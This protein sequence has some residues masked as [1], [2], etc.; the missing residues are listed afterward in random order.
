MDKSCLHVGSPPSRGGQDFCQP[1]HGRICD[2]PSP[3]DLEKLAQWNGKMPEQI[4]QCVHKLIQKHCQA[5][6][7]AP[8][9]SAW[10]GDFTY[11]ELDKLSNALASRL[12][13][14]GVGPEVFVP[15]CFEKSRWTPMA[16]VGVMK[17]G[18]AF[19]LLDPLH[20]EARLQSICSTVSAD[21]ILA[22]VQHQALAARLAKRMLV[23]GP[24]WSMCCK[25]DSRPNATSAVVTPSNAIYA[26]FTSGSTGT[27]KGVVITH[28]A[29]SSGV[30][31]YN[32]AL[33]LRNQARILQFASHAFDA[34]I[35]D[36]FT[37]FLSGSCVCIPSERARNNNLAAFITQYNVTWA[38]F[39][40]S[41]LAIIE[42]ERVP[43]LKTVVVAGEGISP[44]TVSRWSS[45]VRLV[46]GYGPSECAGLGAIQD[47]I[48][49]GS[50]VRN[51]GR[52]IA[53]VRWIVDPDDY[54][55]LLPIGAVGELLIEGPNVGREYINNPVKSAA[56]FIDPPAW[57][58]QF[59]GHPNSSRKMYRTGDLAKYTADGSLHFIGRKDSQVKLRGQR[60]EL[61]EVEHHIRLCFPGV[62]DVVAELVT[63]VEAGRATFLVAFIWATWTTQAACLET[64]NHSPVAD[65][66]E[67]FLAA[68][69]GQF[70]DAILEAESRLHKAVPAYMVPAVFLPVVAMPLAKSGKTDRRRLR[71]H[72]AVLSWSAM[73]VY[74]STGGRKREPATAAEVTL[75]Q[76]WA[77]VLK[78]STEN[79]AADDNFFRLG[80]DSISAMQMVAAA[81]ADGLSLT[82]ADIFHYPQL[83]R[84]SCVLQKTSTSDPQSIAPP[85]SLLGHEYAVDSARRVAME[86]CQIRQ[87]QIVDMYP[88]TALQEGLMAL[89]A[90]S[91][92]AYT[93]HLSYRIPLYSDVDLDRFHSAWSAVARANPILSTRIVQSDRG[94]LQVVVADDIRWVVYENEEAYTT[95]GPTACFGLGKPLVEMAIVKPAGEASSGRFILSMHHSVYDAWSL[96]LLLEQAET[97]FQG[98]MLLPRPFSPFIAYLSETN[99]AATAFWETEFSGLST[100]SFPLLP[101]PTY[102]ASPTKTLTHV[103][104]LLH[105]NN[106]GQFTLSTR[107]RLAW[108][109]TLSYIS[110][111]SDIVFGLTVTGRSAPVTDIQQI[112]G[113]TIAT[114]PLRI[115]LNWEATVAQAL[116]GIQEHSAQL[117]PYE[118][119]GLQNIQRLS[120]DAAAACQFQNL[121][122]VQPSQEDTG[123]GGLFIEGDRDVLSDEGAFNT[124]PLTL[125]CGLSSG[126]IEVQAIYDEQVLEETTVDRMLHQ[127]GHVLGQIDQH[128]DAMMGTVSGLSPMDQQQ[129]QNWNRE[130]PP[131]NRCV[132]EL[133]Q[134]RCWA[135]PAAPAVCAWDGN[136]SYGELD[137]LSSELAAHLASR[138]VG[139]EAFVPL[140]FEK[141]RWTP[142]AMVGVMKAGGAFVLLDPS[143]PQARL[144][145]ICRQVSAKVIVTSAANAAMVADILAPELATHVVTVG[146]DAVPWREY[147]S[148]LWKASSVVP[149][150]AVYAVFTSGSTG[151]P[152]GTVIE[153]SS[154]CTG[155]LAHAPALGL[156][157]S[158]RVFQFASYAFDNSIAN[159]LTTLLVGGCVCIPSEEARRS[160]LPQAIQ[161]LRANFCPLTPTVARI[162]EPASLP[163]LQTVVLLGEA[164]RRS[165]IEKWIDHVQLLN[166]YGP[167]ECSVIATARRIDRMKHDL[168]PR[169][170]GLATGC[171]CWIVDALDHR[172]LLPIGAVGELVIEGPIVGRGYLNDPE[173]TAA[174]FIEPPPWLH[175]F[176]GQSPGRRLYKTGDLVQYAVDGSLRFVGRK[177][178]QVK[179]R[180]QRIE[181][182]E[183]E[184]HLRQCWPGAQDVVAEVAALA[185]RPPILIAFIWGQHPDGVNDN[186]H[187]QE[188][189]ILAVP[190]DSFRAA[191][192]MAEAH[193][194]RSLPAYMVPALFLPVAAI[195]TTTT[196]KT[197]RRQLRERVA[198]L[199]QAEMEACT[200]PQVQKQMPTTESETKLQRLWA[201]V[202]H[203]PPETIGLDD[204]FFRLGGD[205]IVAMKLAGAAGEHGLG[206]TVSEV[207]HHPR[208]SELSTRLQSKPSTAA[209]ETATPFALLEQD[210]I[211]DVLGL[212]MKQCRVQR[213]QISNIYPCT[214]LQE[215]LM[216]LTAKAPGTY[217]ARVSYRLPVDINL[218]D[219]RAVW[220]RVANANPILN[221]RIIQS[222]ALGCFQ[223]VVSG[224]V[225]WAVHEHEDAHDADASGASFGIGEPLFCA[226]VI[227]SRSLSKPHRFILSM[228]HAVYDAWSLPLLLEQAEA[229]LQGKPLV[230]RP[231]SAFISY[232]SE[233]KA[234]AASFWQ[235]EFTELNTVSFPSLP[236]P[237]YIPSP[238]EALRH[239]IPLPPPNETAS[240]FTMSTKLRL[241]WALTLS[242]Y[243]NTS[244]IVF[245]LTVTGRGVPVAGIDQMTGPTIATIPLRIRF[246]W[247]RDDTVVQALQVVQDHSTEIIPYE[248]SGLQNIRRLSANA[249]AACQFQNLLAIQPRQKDYERGLF[250]E[251]DVKADQGP[252]ISYA[253]T[254]QCDLYT[255]SI[256]VE[257]NY[258]QQIIGKPKV[259]QL[260]YQLAHVIE[261]I[262][263]QPNATVKSI[264]RLL[265]P[266]DH[267]QLQQWNENEPEQVHQCVHGLVHE[268]CL[269]Q[270]DAPAICAWD[271]DF[272]YRQLDDLSGI[273]GAHL[274]S[275]GVGPEVFVPLCFEKSRWTPVAMVGVMK[276]GGAFVLLDPSHPQVRLQS[277]CQQVS[278]KL[279]VASAQNAAIAKELGVQVVTIGDNQRAWHQHDCK[280][281]A[282]GANP[283]NAV[284]AVFTSGSTG[285]PKGPVMEHASFSTAALAQIKSKQ[286]TPDIRVFQ[287]SS[288]A[289]DTCILDM[290]TTLLA[291]GC[292]CIPSE[293]DRKE[294]MTK[295]IVQLQ[296]NYIDL[297]PSFA[298]T[299]TPHDIPGVRTLL[300]GGEA[301]LRSDIDQ[302]QPYVRLIN[303]YG[304]AECSA[305]STS[306]CEPLP[307]RDALNIGK[308][309]GCV[310]WVV[311]EMDHD[312]LVPIGAVGE[313]MIEG[314]IVGRGYL[315]D[316]EKTAAAFIKP[317]VWMHHFRSP[318]HVSSGTLKLYK[319]GDLVQYTADGSLRFIGRKDTQVKLRGQRVELGE[320]EHNTRQCF[321]G[322]RDVVAEVVKPVEEGRSPMLVAFVWCGHLAVTPPP[323][324]G[325]GDGGDRVNHIKHV[326]AAPTDDFHAAISVARSRLHEVVPAYMVPALFLPLVMVPL[327]S[328][329]KA[330]RRQ[331]REGAASLSRAEID[332]YSGP[333]TAQR[334]PATAA[335]QTLQ[336]LW[337]RVFNMPA[338]DI[339]ANDNFFHLGGDSITAM[340]LAGAARADGLGL[341]VADVFKYPVLCRQ[342]TVISQISADVPLPVEPAPFSM[343]DSVDPESFRLETVAPN[344]PF[345]DSQVLDAFPTTEFQEQ[346]ISPY[347][348][349]YL[350][351]TI[352]GSVDP[353]RLQAAC[354][355][356][357]QRYPI[358]RTTFV[359]SD[360]GF[361][362][363]TLRHLDATMDQMSTRGE[364][365]DSSSRSLCSQDSASPLPFGTAPFK[366]FLVSEGDQSHTLI[367][368]LSHAQYDGISLPVMYQDLAATYQGDML[369]PIP[370]FSLYMQYRLSRR[371]ADVYQFWHDFL[372]NSAMTKLNCQAI[373]GGGHDTATEVPVSVTKSMSLPSPPV[374]ITMAT[375]VKAAWSFVLMQLT[376]QTDL[377][378][379]QLVNGR[380]V[381]IPGSER[382]LGPCISVIPM[383]VILQPG[384]TVWDLLDHV[385]TQQA[386]VLP[387]ETSDLRDIVPNSTSWPR[388]TDYQI[389]VHHESIGAD[390][391]SF[392]LNGMEC[393]SEIVA[394]PSI[395]RGL[396]VH[397]EQMGDS[398]NVLISASS[399]VVNSAFA[400]NI[401]DRLCET[402]SFFASGPDQP[403]SFD[404]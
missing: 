218:D 345:D 299:L 110:N 295:A 280:R 95:R 278:A 266:G 327:T 49:P 143:H 52:A 397:S 88:C 226:S 129:L 303:A 244:D 183:V 162:L 43:C 94:S 163:T 213:S 214:A 332:V 320:V 334:M 90:K 255:D 8:A 28:S 12:S 242:A 261:Q 137:T 60:I 298:R 348:S 336:H 277:I 233:A 379:G 246:D 185:G 156:M 58:H 107:L 311:D 265:S 168:D 53:S 141:S 24:E 206:L 307:D 212:A 111:T 275:Q 142:V 293:T 59:R 395:P 71:D 390:D 221:T 382:I 50:D 166:E 9:V 191:I 229:A 325:D 240:D 344:L 188:D 159:T 251:E 339:G 383:R 358:L 273:L 47:R 169:N 200:G 48:G 13:D 177:D 378:Y 276:A 268:R 108:A 57:L 128:P 380:N 208:L 144:Q 98:K 22:S 301:V 346:C 316:P 238:T 77:R 373:G 3:E 51:I 267:Q 154:F 115:Q 182:G 270:P 16:M 254:V 165:D 184:H 294:N 234:T 92:G 374:G 248:Q 381:P 73:E 127:L 20:P 173:K 33:Q 352:P 260:L 359:P 160:N 54:H 245:G 34:S 83:S 341:A 75:Q 102:I 387:F 322:A 100:A 297:T 132:H 282:S 222:N 388:S 224:D 171:V 281:Q 396:K 205:S 283:N 225:Q 32:Q 164:P 313:L 86:Q 342:S 291:G 219:F 337:G 97:A 81:H 149:S 393:T 230:P 87:D 210:Q 180:G 328:T 264:H 235:S 199:T 35:I 204:S 65:D 122:V 74:T 302:W 392:S 121:L 64:E 39:T 29:F 68:P 284:Y 1:A 384:W 394:P 389:V 93:A 175:A 27:P 202:L 357:A 31:P 5:Q 364:T 369:P 249:A 179:L 209:L 192:S 237:T 367:I 181:L 385:Q 314:P 398:L 198:I 335:E 148:R 138:G 258:D 113:P 104:P 309:E 117:I 167:A 157:S 371:S 17:A 217:T 400:S 300:L 63:P 44:A 228:H 145:G 197:D 130:V 338:D 85:F 40:P 120:N 109:L 36:M 274:A 286:F 317:P 360:Q 362:Q 11:G 343:L 356:L 331:L 386:R 103:I 315:N 319:T 288:Y 187:N 76:L 211:E 153:H 355:A 151:T 306:K 78:L 269:L 140:C 150:N 227:P 262:N 125:L 340:R 126:S 105:G 292:I 80:G 116:Q 351:L 112:T 67:G 404:G 215:G 194:Y 257:A 353:D 55:Q 62:R 391:A 79:V 308:G 23:V 30:L 329:G 403:L 72:A 123:P 272:T 366:V 176:R 296:A 256:E 250:A 207:F 375:A 350:L 196:G 247:D 223:V 239:V 84:L 377:V 243:C 4:E 91:A 96:P 69:S 26:V 56:A 193:L 119:S 253:L 42:P 70:C 347:H 290:I 131:V 152:K 401:L 195:P 189:S 46:F 21:L 172:R 7:D 133:I 354:Q 263:R 304:P 287:F 178:T 10:D 89:T 106:P 61:G 19:V 155:A 252:F 259:Q 118:Q 236:S 324:G 330:D 361:I 368:R 134:E 363:I 323:H 135:Q 220:N 37:A 2:K 310:C 66:P 349:T 174:A 333:K 190:S 41:V 146:D 18:G 45:S 203:L 25:Y 231:F 216:A 370:S 139:P 161:D 241:A 289:F 6:A 201:E 279:L 326:L 124:Y 372:E 399:R 15:L 312:R 271:G 402:I 376:R 101:S 147:N 318:S 136:L 305:E 114:V 186:N 285:N 82:V 14:H 38:H 365:L 158:S 99:A 170:I 321:P 232:I